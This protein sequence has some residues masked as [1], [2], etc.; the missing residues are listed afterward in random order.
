[1]V[2]AA[3]DDDAASEHRLL[4]AFHLAQHRYRIEHSRRFAGRNI[5]AFR[6]VR[7]DGEKRRVEATALHRFQDVRDLRIELERDAEIDDAPDL[8]VEHVARQSIF[9]DAEAH[10]AAGPRTRVD[11]RHRMAEATKMIRGRQARRPR[12]DDEDAL[13]GFDLR[14]VELPS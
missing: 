5:S 9:R 6:D 12:A 2:A 3:V 8:R 10:H 1:R 4:F 14:T 13:P 7:A 11:D